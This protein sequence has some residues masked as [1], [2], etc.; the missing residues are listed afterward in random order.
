MPP[1]PVAVKPS[2]TTKPAATPAPVDEGVEMPARE[3]KYPEISAAI[4]KEGYPSGP[5]T[6]AQAKG[7]IGWTEIK[8]KNLDPLLR[9][10]SKKHIWCTNNLGNRPIYPSVYE[11]YIQEIMQHRWQFNGEP[12]II[13]NTG[14]VLN[15]Q[16]QL[17]ALILA[18]QDRTGDNKF[19]WE[20]T[21]DGPVTLEKMITFGIDE[22]DEVIN[23]MDTCRPRSLAD[24]LYRSPFFA[25][26]PAGDRKYAAKLCESGIRLLWLRTGCDSDQWA[27]R[28]THA[29][30]LDFLTRHDRLLEAIKHIIGEDKGKEKKISKYLT[31]GY[32]SAML[33]LMG[34]CK[35]DGEDYHI[36]ERPTQE[37][38]DF[39]LWDKALD[40]WRSLPETD[41]FK[42]LRHAIGMLYDE[43][44]ETDGSVAEKIA[45]IVNAWLLF[46][47]DTP[48]TKENL[49]PEG[50]YKTGDD[51]VTKLA[52]MPIVGGID[53]GSPE[54]KGKDKGEGS[55]EDGGDGDPELTPEEIEAEKARVRAAAT[56]SAKP[57]SQVLFDLKEVN[58]TKLLLFKVKDGYR[59]WGEEA[60]IL[61]GCI[62][63]GVK[64]GNTFKIPNA[65]VATN[66]FIEVVDSLITAGHEV[67]VVDQVNGEWKIVSSMEKSKP[68]AANGAL[69][70]PNNEK[71]PAEKAAG[72]AKAK[73]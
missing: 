14:I 58:P 24:V 45:I 32:A 37:M 56:K 39:S 34:T 17:V 46:L 16:H 50:L 6:V 2:P 62:K 36:K 33:Y 19:H 38:L 22:S 21:W 72:K 65:T 40:F 55:G 70:G 7:L 11:A 25:D 51:G 69:R 20:A 27:P 18:E 12:I 73:K 31:A 68:A 8:Q 49:V 3:V 57:M 60:A 10:R 52:Y 15:G 9:D 61:N 66:T 71:L 43:A 13:S 41:E 30:A 26:R 67:A 64:M 54:K 28:R 29:E 23:T 48:F 44:N 1:T 35:S 47:N 53:I 4:C 63:T 42:E 5:I 59:A